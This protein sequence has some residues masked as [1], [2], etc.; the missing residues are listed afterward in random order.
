MFL[1]PP[2]YDDEFFFFF[3]FTTLILVTVQRR[4]NV[5]HS[6]SAFVSLLISYRLHFV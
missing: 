3:F 1:D 2:E 6:V 5:V 4:S